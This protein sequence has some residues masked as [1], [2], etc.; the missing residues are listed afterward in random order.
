MV[1]QRVGHKLANDKQ[2][3]IQGHTA[4]QRQNKDSDSYL[5]LSTLPHCLLDSC[6]DPELTQP[7]NKHLL[8]TYYG[9]GFIL[10]AEAAAVRKQR[11]L[12][13]HS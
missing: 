5:F 2:I 13:S 7:V 10:D 12:P 9:P 11:L 6:S 4:N 1:L 3:I 8:N